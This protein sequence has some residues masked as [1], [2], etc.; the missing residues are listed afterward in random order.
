MP[1]TLTELV[2]H[3]MFGQS[4]DNRAKLAALDKSQAI[5]EFSLTG[6]ILTANNNFLEAMGYKLSEIV[7]KHHSMFVRTEDRNDPAYKAFW[8]DLNRGT[9]QSAEF[10]RI[11]KSGNE[12][13]IQAS[14]NP[15]FNSSGRPYKV[16]K[17]ATDITAEKLKAADSA[18]Q[19][20]AISKSQAVIS[21][22]LNGIIQ[23]ANSNFLN[24]LGYEL[25]EIQGQHHRM[26]VDPKEATTPE[27][28]QFWDSLARGEYQAAEYKRIGKNGQEIWIQASYNP[29]FDMSGNPFKVVKY[30]TNITA[31][32]QERHARANAQD[33]ITSGIEGIL[34]A[35]SATSTQSSEAQNALERTSENVQSVASGTEE[36]AA[37][38]GEISQQVSSAL[39]I[40]V[41]A[42]T[43]AENTNSIVSG[44]AEAGQRIGEVV[45]LINTIAEQTNLLALNATIEAARAGEAGK[46]FAVVA[47]EVKNLATQTSKATEDI[48]A[49][50][51]GVQNSTKEA[52][53]ALEI[54]T[55]TISRINEISTAIATA[56]EEQSAVTN[57]ISSNMQM[58]AGG[59]D[60]INESMSEITASAQTADDATQKVAESCKA[61]G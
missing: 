43:Q 30:A 8:E 40:S 60:T 46:G 39:E 34:K 48:G 5:I 33:E 12:I 23:E 35:I 9:F 6:E 17:F 50:I 26:F 2:G 36:L 42:V 25:S 59:V 1:K 61:L 7:G 28:K 18:G 32:V 56:V 14:Y 4:R 47:S 3:S 51:T 58:A 27:Y 22:D 10:R 45:E 49:H 21:F 55:S 53:S 37:S 13:W 19:L 24:T 11:G 29:I 52:V 20:E 44:L 16:I 57:E 38:V 15:L 41:E 54:I 31:Q